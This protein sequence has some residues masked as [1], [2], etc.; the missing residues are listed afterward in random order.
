MIII[1]YKLMILKIHIY[2]SF[3]SVMLDCQHRMRPQISMLA[4][5][6]YNHPIYD[7]EL[8]D[9]YPN[10]VGMKKNVF[11]INHKEPESELLDLKSKRNRFEASFLSKLCQYLLKQ[12]YEPSQIT[13]ITM[14]LGQL[15]EIRNELRRIGISKIRVST[16]DNFQGEESDIVLLSLV[17]SNLRRRIG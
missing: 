2:P 3:K 9:E 6:F 1:I 10:V 16:V 11:F 5:L 7:H 15:I 14:Y 17:R 13:V 8:V 4:K 12:D